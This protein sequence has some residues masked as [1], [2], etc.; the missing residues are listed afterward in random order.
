MNGSDKDGFDRDLKYDKNISL[1]N[2][3]YGELPQLA[4]SKM[5]IS[6][7]D[8]T[9]NERSSNIECRWSNQKPTEFTD[10]IIQPDQFEYID[11]STLANRNFKNT[12][13]VLKRKNLASGSR[14][15]S[16][17]QF[18]NSLTRSAISQFQRIYSQQTCNKTRFP[19]CTRKGKL[20]KKYMLLNSV[21][22]MF[23]NVKKIF[24]LGR[25]ENNFQHDSSS[26]LICDECPNFCE[27]DRIPVNY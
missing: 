12:T 22:N 14:D 1:I 16:S 11:P 5:D 8:V 25:I 26:L 4:I 19:R 21:K 15:I 13:E 2:L 20:T 27:S 9:F 6:E 3:E 24:M 17:N 10:E 7:L 18:K 23:T